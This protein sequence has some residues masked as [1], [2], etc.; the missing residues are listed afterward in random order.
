MEGKDAAGTWVRVAGI[1]EE[2]LHTGGFVREWVKEFQN[3]PF[4]AFYVPWANFDLF[5]F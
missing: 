5:R 4:H 2:G 1:A 3:S